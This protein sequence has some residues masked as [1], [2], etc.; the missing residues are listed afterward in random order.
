MIDINHPVP[1]VGEVID[2]IDMD[3]ILKKYK[4]DDTTSYHPWKLLKVLIYSYLN[5]V[6]SSRRIEALVKWNSY[7]MWLAGMQHPLL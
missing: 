7:F 6:Y 2:N 5:S 1:V 3:I 4:K